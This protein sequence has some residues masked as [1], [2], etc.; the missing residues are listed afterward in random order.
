MIELDRSPSM[1][2]LPMVTSLMRMAAL[3]LPLATV[4]ASSL[5][6]RKV[7]YTRLTRWKHY[8]NTNGR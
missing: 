3:F 5:F 7:K 2:A 1:L 6:Y 8:S 4:G